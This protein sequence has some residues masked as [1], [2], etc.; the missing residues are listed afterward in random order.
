MGERIKE[1]RKMLNMTQSEFGEKVGIS[2]SAVQKIEYGTSTP[3]R[4]TLQLI[5][6]TFSVNEKWLVSG[7][8]KMFAEGI[9]KSSNLATL[10]AKYENMPVVRAI[11]DAY[12]TLPV[13]DQAKV[14]KFVADLAVAIANGIEPGI[15]V[16]NLVTRADD[17]DN[18]DDTNDA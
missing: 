16:A 14:E 7:E 1:L 11:L 12:L 6:V 3:A 2:K 17:A 10:V 9:T 18:A 5:C 4:S 13:A 15:P 8:G